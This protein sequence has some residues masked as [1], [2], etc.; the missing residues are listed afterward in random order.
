[1]GIW[2][3]EC[4]R[5]KIVELS[6]GISA[7]NRANINHT[8]WSIYREDYLQLGIAEGAKCNAACQICSNR[9]SS[10]HAKTF[11]TPVVEFSA[12]PMLD[13]IDPARIVSLSIGGGE[14]SIT[15]SVI[16]LLENKLH[17]LNLQNISFSANGTRA[18]TE[19]IPLLERGTRVQVSISM[20][21]TEKIFE[22]NRW[23]IKWDKFLAT[24]D[25]YKELRAEYPNLRISLTP[26]LSALTIIDYRNILLFAETHAVAMQ[27]SNIQTPDVLQLSKTNTLTLK[28]KELLLSS[29]FAEDR[30]FARLVA[31]DEHDTTDELCE[32]IEFG[33][34]K[35][36]IQFNDYYR[37][38]GIQI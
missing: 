37:S 4:V 2:P 9:C 17:K 15:S 23:P 29:L 18:M 5:C 25:T 31:T 33:D 13:K 12:I 26:T 19:I 24:L 8:T 22:Y 16:D 11:N 27:L 10:F 35:R 36:N 38:Y 30:Q 14:P 7:R 28:G 6:G 3:D 34:Q 20:D 32:F 1:M 21:G